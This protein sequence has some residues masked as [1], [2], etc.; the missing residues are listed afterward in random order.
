MTSLFAARF[1]FKPLFFA[2]FFLLLLLSGAIDLVHT[3][4][5][6]Q[7][8]AMEDTRPNIMECVPG[9]MVLRIPFLCLDTGIPVLSGRRK[10]W[11]HNL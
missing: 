10:C 2:L 1:P 6:Y 5:A 9:S 8:E 4:A 7:E 11:P 3:F